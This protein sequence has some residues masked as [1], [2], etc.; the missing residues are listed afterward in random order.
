MDILKNGKLKYKMGLLVLSQ[1][2]PDGRKK[3]RKGQN[4]FLTHKWKKDGNFCGII[5]TI[6]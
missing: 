3:Y 4:H 6:I 1:N 5:T 2:R